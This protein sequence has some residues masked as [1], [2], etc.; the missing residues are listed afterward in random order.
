MKARA[1]AADGARPRLFSVG[2]P[3][4]AE[5]LL[6]MAVG[7]AGTALAARLSDTAGAGFALAN[8]VAAMLFL[9][10]RV[11]A[12]GVGVVVAQQLGAG[13]RGAADALARA[14]LGASTWMGLAAAAL[15]A[16]A[17]GPMLALLNA[18][19]EVAAQARPF[20]QWLALPL[21]L[22]AFNASFAAVLRAHLRT[23]ATLGVI[24]VVH[25]TH[26]LLA[27]PLMT[28]LGGA[29]PR[30]G[31][32]G[33]ALAV[34]V[35]RLVG[36][37][38]YLWLWRERLGIAVRPSD[39]WRLPRAE[40]SAILHIGGPG[41]AE[42]VAWRLGFLVSVAAVGHLGARAL[43]THAY[44]MQVCHIVLLSSWAIGLS[45]EMLVGRLVGAG[46]LHEAHAL[47]RRALARGLLASAALALAFALAGP[48]VLRLFTQDEAILVEG[49]RLLWLMLLLEPGR[50][51]NLI[52][53]NALRAAGDARY[54]VQAGVVSMALVMAGGSWLLGVHA[55][56]GLAGVW[57]AYAA[58][59]WTRG[60]TM[61]RRWLGL[62]WVP[63]ARRMRRRVGGPRSA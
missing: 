3:L 26:L 40:L 36:A 1:P 11:V 30:L 14:A 62:R 23:R 60:L 56:L 48:W 19:P 38:L 51:F 8:N 16:G 54:P 43:A 9:L 37:A 25:T 41:A 58:D 29:V 12:A 7:V 5:L 34:F 50:A 21:L 28:G 24:G 39:G 31:L 32:A 2:W 61:W 46:R 49:R 27:V 35:A 47:V 33:F 15:A 42:N 4:Y 22:D 13:R 44:V 20:L 52:V 18:P 53:I 59:E 57:L 17:A 55:G 6:G 63:Y 45:M 10:F